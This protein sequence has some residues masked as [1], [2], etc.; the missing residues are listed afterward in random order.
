MEIKTD[1]RL[2]KVK[3]QSNYTNPDAL[4]RLVGR[5]TQPLFIWKDIC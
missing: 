4:A 5:I 2:K 3:R 1:I